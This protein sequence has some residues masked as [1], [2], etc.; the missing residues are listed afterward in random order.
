MSLEHIPVALLL[1][2]SMAVG[3]GGG[4]VKNYFCIKISNG[5][6]DRQAYNGVTSLAAAVILL[7]WG[8]ISSVS[9][10][11]LILGTAFGIIT[12]LQQITSLQAMERGPWAYTSV[13]ISLSALI[14]S[15]SG[16]LFWNEHIVWPQI[17]GLALMAGCL[18]LSVDNKRDQKKAS[19]LWLFYCMISFFCTG[20]I[21]VMQ[22][23]HQNS[24]SKSE[25][26]AFLVVAFLVSFVYSVV[27]W[28]FQH[29]RNR[30][31]KGRAFGSWLPVVLM[32]GGG[33]SAAVI[34]KLNLFLSGVMESAVFFPIVNGGGLVL[35]TAAAVV[36][37]RE[38]LTLKQWIGLFLGILSVVFVCNPFN[39]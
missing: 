28:R 29:R 14:P 9:M 33:F 20:L 18:V 30:D 5:P 39:K 27:A 6:G 2:V 15:L 32:I 1:A 26:N 31:N 36:F 12:A 21:G 3:L 17:A 10:F 22:K 25:L 13:I 37:F 24:G 11:T 8:G 35:T 23:W 38:R 7:L 4:I 19:L 34:N 16:T